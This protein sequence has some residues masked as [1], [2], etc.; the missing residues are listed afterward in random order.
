MACAK[1]SAKCFPQIK[2]STDQ[3]TIGNNY[4]FV[5]VLTGPGPWSIESN[6]GGGSHGKEAQKQA[7]S[8]AASSL[9]SSAILPSCFVDA[10]Q[11]SKT[12][13]PEQKEAHFS[14]SP[15]SSW[16]GIIQ[17]SLGTSS[18]AKVVICYCH[19]LKTGHSGNPKKYPQLKDAARVWRCLC[20]VICCRVFNNL[21]PKWH[22]GPAMYSVGH[23][24]QSWEDG[25]GF[26]RYVR[27][28]RLGSISEAGYHSNTHVK[29]FF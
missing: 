13:P 16:L 27:T 6:L 8:R 3:I 12:F 24:G 9:N 18:V 20:S 7:E 23:T 2:S 5:P 26:H 17:E 14:P 28:G 11:N 4:C 22:H 10:T 19:L 21:I 1:H 29:N 15:G 25:R